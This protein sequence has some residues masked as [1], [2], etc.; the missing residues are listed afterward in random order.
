VA[1][2][3]PRVGDLPD[4]M[5]SAGVWTKTR[6]ADVPWT[7]DI[8]HGQHHLQAIAAISYF[9][10]IPAIYY[11]HGVFPWVEQVPVHPRIRTYVMMCQWMVRFVESKFAIPQERVV[12]LPN[13]VNTKR[14]SQV[15]EPPDR[16]QRAVLFSNGGL[17]ADD[18][19]RLEKACVNQ[20]LSLDKIGR[21]YGTQQ[22]RP[23]IFLLDYDLVFAAGKSALEAMACGCAVIPV[24]PG[25]AGNLI[26][27]ENFEE[28]S[29]SNFS[30][31]F[32]TSA[33]QVDSK[34]L[35]GEL[36]RYSPKTTMEVTEKVRSGRDLNTAVDRLE[37]LYV[38]AAEDYINHKPSDE[39]AEFAPYLERISSEVD[40]MWGE[41]EHH[42][43][44]VRMQLTAEERQHWFPALLHLV[45][46]KILLKT[47]SKP[48]RGLD[49][50]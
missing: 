43:H 39:I 35:A 24:I 1:V 14:F 50:S 5:Y 3:C 9:L 40:A 42:R 17:P 8:I 32:Y 45:R 30:P 19:R 2:F 26:T 18:L 49:S 47:S 36:Q 6:L 41:L 34:W 31:R 25:Q 15:R 46:S 11:C 48:V 13:F 7:P 37:K 16:P 27:M 29:Y 10:K 38:A 20:G 28:R 44:N 33:E 21:V 23:E 22:P 12:A 4:I